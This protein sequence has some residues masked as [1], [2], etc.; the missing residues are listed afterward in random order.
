MKNANKYEERIICFIDILG[1]KTKIDST[2]DKEDDIVENINKINELLLLTR[3]ELDIEGKMKFSKS[4]IATQFSDSI[5]ISF[6]AKE[7]GEIIYTLLDILTLIMKCVMK[8]FLIR[9]GITLGKIIHNDKFIFGPGMNIAYELESEVANYPRV[10]LDNTIIEKAKECPFKYG[11]SRSE[12][13]SIMGIVS[14]DTDNMYYID[15]INKAQQTLNY[16]DFDI[17]Q[18]IERIKSIILENQKS[19]SI[20]I[21][22]KTDWL[23]NKYNNFVES[24]IEKDNL[25][26]LRKE[27]V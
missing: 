15:Y 13:E 24:T 16:P 27:G 22:N 2:I 1:F 3:K 5:V 6:L 23:I 9:G 19:K 7:E 18:Y 21:K 26:K 4:K 20:S 11:N 14:I 12:E 17:P 10:I 8:G 25:C